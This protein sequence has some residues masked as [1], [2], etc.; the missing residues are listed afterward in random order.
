M[1]KSEIL[2]VP[3]DCP[4]VDS[5]QRAVAIKWLKLMLAAFILSWIFILPSCA[6][7]V[8]TPRV[9]RHRHVFVRHYHSEQYNSNQGNYNGNNGNRG[10]KENHRD[11]DKHKK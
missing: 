5:N 11:K 6:V 10:H 4:K 8:Q 9:E 2:I 7:E 1:K 3:A